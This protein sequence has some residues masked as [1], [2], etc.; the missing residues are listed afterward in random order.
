MLPK[1]EVLKGD[2]I[3]SKTETI[4]NAANNEF[5][6]GSGVAGAIKEAGGNQI[7]IDAMAK[8]P[9]FPGEAIAT[10]LMWSVSPS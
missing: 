4:V 9:K 5:W 1:I 7:E 3:E 8:G 10:T 6:M 2:I